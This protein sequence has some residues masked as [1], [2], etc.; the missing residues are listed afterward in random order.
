[1]RLMSA[2][3]H[4]V[5]STFQLHLPGFDGTVEELAQRVERRHVSPSQL[6]LTDITRQFSGY[7]EGEETLDLAAVAE[8]VSTVSRLMLWKSRTLLLEDGDTLD[9]EEAPPRDAMKDEDLLSAAVSLRMREGHESFSSPPRPI[10]KVRE[11]FPPTLLRRTWANMQ[12]RSVSA[13]VEVA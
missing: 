6:P 5:R 10:E 13:A 8:F 2:M 9:H 7:M 3:N 4:L 1:M 12:D 11:P